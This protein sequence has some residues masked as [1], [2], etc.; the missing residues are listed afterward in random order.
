VIAEVLRVHDLAKSFV[1][2]KKIADP[3]PGQWQTWGNLLQY[4]AFHV[5]YHT[6]Q[7][8]SARHLLGHETEDN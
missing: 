1:V 4:Q 6:G 8:Y 3:Y 5:A 7:A 2:D